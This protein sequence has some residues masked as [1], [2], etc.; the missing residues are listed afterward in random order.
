[1]DELGI[2]KLLHGGITNHYTEQRY[3]F[4]RY[5]SYNIMDCV[6]M[7]LLEFKNNDY[8][9]LLALSNVSELAMFHRQ[10]TIVRDSTFVFELNNRRVIS[11]VG[12]KVLTPFDELLTKAGGTV[13]SPNRARHIGC[14]VIAEDP[15]MPTKVV[16]GGNDLDVEA[17]YP[18]IASCMNI[19]KETKLATCVSIGSFAHASVEYFFSNIPSPLENAVALGHMYYNLPDYVEAEGLFDRFLTALGQYGGVKSATD[20][21]PLSDDEILAILQQVM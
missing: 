5:V 15:T 3:R 2:G 19:A 1:M 18:N 10:M 16:V 7:Q 12:Y 9:Q 13:L 4:L 21:N 20:N 17:E 6:L 11:S 8:I 14:P